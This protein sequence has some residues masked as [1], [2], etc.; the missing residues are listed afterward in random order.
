MLNPI[1]V[2]VELANVPIDKFRCEIFYDFVD[3]YMGSNLRVVARNVKE[4][5]RLIA[6]LREARDSILTFPSEA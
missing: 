1:S 2:E 6:V 3:V 4:V 5:N